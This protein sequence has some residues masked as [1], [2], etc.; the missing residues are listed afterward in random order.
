VKLQTCGS[1]PFS[2]LKVD[3]YVSVPYGT[4]QMMVCLFHKCCMIF[5]VFR[6]VISRYLAHACIHVI[7]PCLL[8]KQA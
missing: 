2:Q 3:F 8:C 5:F 4:Q 7:L 1:L 6:L